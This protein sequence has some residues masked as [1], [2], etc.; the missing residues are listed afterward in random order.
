MCA[1]R[2][3]SKRAVRN[4]PF[5]GLSE[6]PLARALSER[7]GLVPGRL[8]LASAACEIVLDTSL[9]AIVMTAFRA[10]L[11]EMTRRRPTAAHVEDSLGRIQ[12]DASEGEF[13]GLC[14]DFIG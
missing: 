1:E 10:L 14:I 12:L 9:V 11:R 5:A 4:G 13:C 8:D 2:R 3:D 7:M 6:A